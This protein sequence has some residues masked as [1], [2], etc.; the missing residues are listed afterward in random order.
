MNVDQSGDLANRGVEV[1]PAAQ[2]TVILQ[3]MQDGH[4]SAADQLLPLIYDELRGIAEQMFRQER[5]S[6]TLQPTALVHEAYLR[7]V[8]QPTISWQGR[9]HFY[10]VAAQAMRRILINHAEKHASMKRGGDRKR[11]TL[12]ADTPEIGVL[13]TDREVDLLALN[14]AL[15]RLEAMDERQCRVVEMRYFGGLTVDETA[16]ALGIAPR[17]V[18]LDWKMARAWLYVQLNE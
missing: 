1:S 18:K 7:L 4:R 15:T 13:K 9:A 6:H 2:V 17:T 8:N 14:D 3:R 12:C 5:A 11:L 10:A 16:E